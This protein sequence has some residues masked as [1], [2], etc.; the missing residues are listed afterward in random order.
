MPP[1]L[2]VSALPHPAV[3]HGGRC[4]RVPGEG[5]GRQHSPAVRCAQVGAV[6]VRESGHGQGVQPGGH[7]PASRL[8]LS[9]AVCNGVRYQVRE[10]AGEGGCIPEFIPWCVEFIPFD[11]SVPSEGRTVRRAL[12]RCT[13]SCPHFTTP[14]SLLLR[15]PPLPPQPHP[16]SHRAWL[17]SRQ[18][19][20]CE[21]LLWSYQRRLLAVPGDC[22]QCSATG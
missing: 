8:P 7:L 18:E 19:D 15:P 12:S 22:I 5:S 16:S 9:A 21:A 13:L 17:P 3:C 14:L 4:V 11:E 10:G 6:R 2:H 20:G 1:G